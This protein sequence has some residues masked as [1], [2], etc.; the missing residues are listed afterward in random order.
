MTELSY[1]LLACFCA[2]W[3]WFSLHPGSFLGFALTSGDWSRLFR[4][5]GNTQLQT[6]SQLRAAGRRSV[7]SHVLLIGL[8]AAAGVSAGNYAASS[9]LL[10]LG[11]V[12]AGLALGYFLLLWSTRAGGWYGAA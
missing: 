12:G 5:L 10:A 9:A 3:F 11:W 6:R 7:L 2:A 1:P 8:S 4:D